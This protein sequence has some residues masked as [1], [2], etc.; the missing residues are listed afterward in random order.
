[1]VSKN[2]TPWTPSPSRAS[3]RHVTLRKQE[4]FHAARCT[5]SK[6]AWEMQTNR[7]ADKQYVV[8]LQPPLGKA[9]ITPCTDW[10]LPR[11]NEKKKKNLINWELKRTHSRG[12]RVF[13]HTR[14]GGRGGFSSKCQAN[15]LQEHLAAQLGVTL[16]L[17]SLKY[18]CSWA[19]NF[20]FLFLPLS[21]QVLVLFTVC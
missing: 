1:M 6:L 11:K 4:G 5:G 14:E 20:F 15:S 21:R 2:Q 12:G 8:L 16:K 9:S 19:W 10:P 7:W 3:P 18:H 17:L 13:E